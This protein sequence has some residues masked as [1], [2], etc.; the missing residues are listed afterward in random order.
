MWKE[1]E[2]KAKPEKKKRQTDGR[3]R[4]KDRQTQRRVGEEIQTGDTEFIHSG[5]ARGVKFL[6]S[7]F[8]FSCS[9]MEQPE[10][11]TKCKVAPTHSQEGVLLTEKSAYSPESGSPGAALHA[12]SPLS[13]GLEHIT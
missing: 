3:R 12:R 6:L 8:V 11:Q 5:G 13:T 7:L 2:R 4:K 9:Q 10:L 1:E